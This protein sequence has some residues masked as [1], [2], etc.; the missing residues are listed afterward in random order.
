MISECSWFTT[1]IST[2]SAITILDTCTPKYT[3]N[4]HNSLWKKWITSK[5]QCKFVYFFDK[6]LE[7]HVEVA[8]KV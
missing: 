4:P 8:C 3:K 7:I 6:A 1:I 5:R 2:L